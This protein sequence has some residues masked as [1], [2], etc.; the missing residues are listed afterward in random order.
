M[1]AGARTAGFESVSDKVGYVCD[2]NRPLGKILI[3]IVTRRD[4][5]ETVKL[6]WV[7]SDD[8]F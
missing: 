1:V 7:S 8:L 5:K 3:Q 6:F 4:T 2:N